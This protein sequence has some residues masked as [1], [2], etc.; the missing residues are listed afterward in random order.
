MYVIS[1]DHFLDSRGAIAVEP[2]PARKLADF[3]TAAVAYASNGNRPDD[4]PQPTCFKC[5]N[6][7]DS[8]VDIGMTEVGLIAWRCQACGSEG[9]ISN[10]RGTFWDLSKNSPK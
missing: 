7:K 8:V 1:L 5:G 10:W 9:E 2:G 4:A 6:P 3:A